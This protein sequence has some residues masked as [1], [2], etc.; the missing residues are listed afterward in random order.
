MLTKL[1][2]PDWSGRENSILNE[3]FL[4]LPEEKR[5]SIINAGFEVFAQNE[6]KHA[7]T[8][9][10]AEKAGISKG[11]LFY[12]FH[13]KKEFYLFLYQYAEKKITDQVISGHFGEITDF[14][15]LCS[16]SA[17]Q[18]FKVLK[19]SPH[20]LEFILRA[21]YS[22]REEVTADVEKHFQNAIASILTNYFDKVDFTKFKDNIDPEEILHMLAWIADGYLHE[23]QRLVAPVDYE[24]LREKYL[25]WS[26]LFK[27]LSYK[28]EYL[29]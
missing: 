23:R 7:S 10:I 11:L 26:K 16:Y 28:E 12:Y 6:Y 9:L 20:I 3:K 24:D 27:Q 13:N 18:K 5:M 15:E 14:F 25:I 8:D 17:E 4:E 2:K 19:I 22:Q 29:V 21:F 1:I